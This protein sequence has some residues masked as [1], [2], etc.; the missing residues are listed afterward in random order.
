MDADTVLWYVRTRKT[1]N[2]IKRNQRQRE[3]LTALLE[4]FISIDAFRRA[5]EFFDTYNNSV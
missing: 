3:V 2:D 5:P 1:T 4:K